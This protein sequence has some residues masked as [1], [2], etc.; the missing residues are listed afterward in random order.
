MGY[1]VFTDSSSSRKSNSL[2]SA[3]LCYEA[4]MND[5]L[6]QNFN[7]EIFK[8]NIGFSSSIKIGGGEMIGILFALENLLEKGLQNEFIILY[9]D[10]QYAI[11]EL[12]PKCG[13]WKG[14][15]LKKFVDIKNQELIINICYKISLFK[16]LNLI[17]IKGHT[18]KQNFASLGNDKADILARSAHRLDEGAKQEDLFNYNDFIRDINKE[19]KENKYFDIIYNFLYEK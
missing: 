13:W 12:D 7:K 10:S 3:W 15:F 18:G 9:S 2:G 8:G 5:I 16:N 1:Y 6:N 4:D 14:H 19:N 17:H 11:K